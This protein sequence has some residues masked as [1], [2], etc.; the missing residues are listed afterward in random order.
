MNNV[1][2]TI[3]TRHISWH[4]NNYWLKRKRQCRRM[5]CS[6]RSCSP[7]CPSI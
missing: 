2:T 3:L 7:I 6:I 1:P 4:K 5:T